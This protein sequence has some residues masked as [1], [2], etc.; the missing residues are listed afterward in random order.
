MKRK[1]VLVFTL[2]LALVPFA[3]AQPHTVTVTF[4]GPTGAV[5]SNAQVFVIASNGTVVANGTTN[6]NGVVSFSLPSGSYLLH[7]KGNFSILYPVTVT[8][9]VSIT[10]DASTMPSVEVASVPVLVDFN[11]TVNYITVTLRTNTTIYRPDAITLSFPEEVKKWYII[12]YKLYNITYGYAWSDHTAWT[13]ETILVLDGYSYTVIAHYKLAFPVLEP[14]MMYALI[15]V[16][17]LLIVFAF[18]AGKKGAKQA[19]ADS[20]RFVQRV[21][22]ERRF[23]KRRV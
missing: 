8:Q 10:V 23:V 16:V 12:P 18:A 14:W 4:K 1:E 21:G 15:G 7:L 2:L 9:S 3:L 11:A 17:V 5:I 20:K 22:G 19:I 13:N 6:E